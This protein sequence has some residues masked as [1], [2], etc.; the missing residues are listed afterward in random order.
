MKL[1]LSF[2]IASLFLFGFAGAESSAYP[3][4]A[5]NAG[6][7]ASNYLLQSGDTIHLLQQTGDTI[8]HEAENSTWSE[9]VY[10]ATC[11]E[12][13]P[14]GNFVPCNDRCASLLSDNEAAYEQIKAITVT[15]EHETFVLDSHDRLLK[16]APD[17]EDPWLCMA[18]LDTDGLVTSG[19]ELN[20]FARLLITG[21]RVYVLFTHENMRSCG[22]FAFDPETGKRREVCV[23][24]RVSQI[25]DGGPGKIL[26]N[27]KAG[28]SSLGKFYLVD[29]ESGTMKELPIML[30]EYWSAI[31]YTAGGGWYIFGATALYEASESGEV[32]KLVTHPD[33]TSWQMF[34]DSADSTLY[35]LRD[36]ERIETYPL[37]G[38]AQTNPLYLRACGNMNLY[39]LKNYTPD[40]SGYMAEHN[41]GELRWCDSP[42]DFDEIAQSLILENDHFDLMTFYVSASHPDRL[43]KKGY[44]YDLS[45]CPS[46]KSYVDSLYPIYRDACMADERI[47]AMPVFTLCNGMLYNSELWAEYKLAD[48][49]F[50]VPETWDALFDCIAYLHDEGLLEEYPLFSDT[51]ATDKDSY[52]RLISN[53]L[54][55][56]CASRGMQDRDL[57]FSDSEL[58]RL[59]ERLQQAEPILRTN[60]ALALTGDGFFYPEA[61]YSDL[62]CTAGTMLHAH[63][64]SDAFRPLMLRLNENAR[65]AVPLQLMLLMV[66]PY[67]PNADDAAGLLD[68]MAQTSSPE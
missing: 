42:A 2:L 61:S 26:V 64:Y 3:I 44:F 25:A 12:M 59:L 54:L 53:L 24:D 51:G 18:E 5:V 11:Y 15:A 47:A 39:M 52:R 13:Q 37:T 8:L 56:Y 27:G 7:M 4:P 46:V 67:S 62:V 48:Q 30:P 34:P 19:D 16:W 43:Y 68:A 28:G 1:R 40:V 10:R 50:N 41:L 63:P 22:L 45:G 66:N 31:R 29:G 57:M 14:D 23:F 65:P 35:A 58:I 49:G 33:G 17:S 36:P 6:L 32:R 21:S 9:W 20:T 55:S 60:D 38:T